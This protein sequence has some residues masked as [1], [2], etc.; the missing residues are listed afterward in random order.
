MPHQMT[1]NTMHKA[2]LG[3]V[4]LGVAHQACLA[5][6][7]TCVQD[8]SAITEICME[9]DLPTNPLE[10]THFLL[11]FTDPANPDIKL[12]TGNLGWAITSVNLLTGG[13][14]I[15][16]AVSLDP[17]Q[18]TD[19]FAVAFTSGPGG[20]VLNAGSIDLTAA[21]WTGE[22]NVTGTLGGD[23]VGD[24]TVVEAPGGSGGSLSLVIAGRSFGAIVAPS[25]SNLFLT[26]FLGSINI[27]RLEVG[28]ELTIIN[29][30]SGPIDIDEIDQNGRVKFWAPYSG[31]LV[32]GAL[33]G[34]VEFASVEF[35]LAAP[36]SGSM[37]VDSIAA[38]GKVVVRGLLPSGSVTISDMDAGSRADFSS[39]EG[40]ILLGTGVP[41]GATVNVIEIAPLLIALDTTGRIDLNGRD[42]D[43]TLFVFSGDG[44]IENGGTVNGT[45]VLAFFSSTFSGTASFTAVDPFGGISM[46]ATGQLQGI[47]DISGDCAGS[48]DILGSIH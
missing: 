12:I 27:G 29:A 5:A 31:S 48:I 30:A 7:K 42:V 26:E 3:I 36:L 45:V 6:G 8:P 17:A 37:T 23:L 46:F 19:N 16:G 14:G 18:P 32:V 20:G 22:S 4:F 2:L 24:L 15:V 10:D 28:G 38:G 9:W 41:S 34:V 40:T 47:I 11:D 21:S 33:T 44:V 35:P 43:G 1:M 13:R 39:V 25:V